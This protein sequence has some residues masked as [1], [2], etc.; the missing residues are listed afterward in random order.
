MNIVGPAWGCPIV[1]Y[2]PGDS[3]L[4][5]TPEEQIEIAE[6]RRAIDVLAQALEALDG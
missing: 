5:H 3:S 4:D 2:G 1:A 6:Y